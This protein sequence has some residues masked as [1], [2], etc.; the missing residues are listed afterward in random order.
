MSVI[1]VHSEGKFENTTKFL[2]ASK[3]LDDLAYKEITSI[4]EQGV[5]ALSAATPVKTGKTAASWGYEIERTKGKTTVVWTNNNIINGVN[6]A[7]IL[8]YGHGT[9]NG[10]YVM[11]SDYINPAL[12]PI[13]DQMTESMWKAVISS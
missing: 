2:E 11:G 1:S 12:K 8:Q 4:A 7:I 3:N 13:F 10:G 9:R 6:V 5:A